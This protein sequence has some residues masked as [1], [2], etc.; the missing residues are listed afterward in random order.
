VNLIENWF[1]QLTWGRR[2]TNSGFDSVR[3]LTDAID[4]W[5]SHRNDNPHQFVWTNIT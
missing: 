3:S 1:A 2:L 4:T 5:T